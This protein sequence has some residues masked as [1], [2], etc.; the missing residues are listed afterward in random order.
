ML[1]SYSAQ[2]VFQKVSGHAVINA[3]FTE[4]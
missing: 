1:G 2:E 4:F 3:I